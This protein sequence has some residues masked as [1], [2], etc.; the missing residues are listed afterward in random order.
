GAEGGGVDSGVV[1]LVSRGT[2][3]VTGGTG[4][5]GAMLARHLVTAYGVRS[6]LLVSRRGLAAPGAEGLVGELT[7]HGARVRV[8][9]CD[10]SDRGAVAQVLAAVP[11]DAPLT[12]VVHTA[13]VLDDGVVT[14]LTPERIDTV[15]AAK[16]DAA[17]HLHELT[18]ELDPALFVL[19]SSASGVLG[20]AGQG[21]YAAA[22]AFLDGLAEY[23]RGRGQAA[24]SIAWGL[25]ASGTAMT[26]HLGDTDT[27][28]MGRGGVVAMSDEQGLM[29]FDAAVAQPRAGVVA[30]RMDTTAMAAQARSGVLAPMLLGLLPG[31]RRATAAAV[32]LQSRLAGLAPAEQHA[33]ILDTVRGQIAEVLG[34]DS[35]A[36]I[37]PARNFQDLGFDSLTAVETRNRLN[38]VTGLRLPATLVFDHLNLLELVRHLVRE[39]ATASIHAES[40]PADPRE[41]DEDRIRQLFARTSLAQLQEAGIIEALMSLAR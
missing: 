37:D 7:E 16:A 39:L 35:G 11:Q 8:L 6:L 13:G 36:V 9:A 33:L 14:A 41:V 18:R 22:N 17:W 2:V 3:V 20:G 10:V 31:V 15:L 29:L 21:N 28:R 19:Y 38:T 1:S 5:L 27:K 12:G 4:G 23:R 30:A 24:V 34:H 40:I 32:S 25:W 26:G